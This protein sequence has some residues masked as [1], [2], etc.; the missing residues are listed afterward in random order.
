V[1]FARNG[2][3]SEIITLKI[4]E[5]IYLTNIHTEMTSV[6]AVLPAVVGYLLA[7]GSRVSSS[8]PWASVQC[9]RPWWGNLLATGGTAAPRATLF[10]F[11]VF[12][13]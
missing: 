3:Q 4:S 9:C 7:T 6:N 10:L 12:S 11:L 13:A 1:C 2:T 5:T 8:Q